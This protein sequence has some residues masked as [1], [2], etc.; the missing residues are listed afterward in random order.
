MEIRIKKQRRPEINGNSDASDITNTYRVIDNGK[1][2]FI[3]VR[4]H[5]HGSVLGIAG[6][7]GV[8]YTDR[9]NNTVSRYVLAVGNACGVN[10]ESDELVEGL[11]A[12]SIRGV[13]LADRHRETREITLTTVQTESSHN[14]PAVLIDGEITENIEL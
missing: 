5:A 13:V 11:S 6:Q 1:E 8:L 7:K 10:I 2:F 12:W 14:Q 3:T 9:D 4:S